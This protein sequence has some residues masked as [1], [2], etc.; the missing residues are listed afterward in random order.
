MT[1]EELHEWA[2]FNLLPQEDAATQLRFEKGEE[3]YDEDYI[4]EKYNENE[5]LNMEYESFNDAP[6]GEDN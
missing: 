5:R 2:K 3:S 6:Y 1:H 4:L